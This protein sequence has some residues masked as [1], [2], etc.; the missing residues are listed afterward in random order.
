MEMMNGDGMDQYCRVAFLLWRNEKLAGYMM[1]VDLEGLEVGDMLVLDG[2]GM[3][4]GQ[5]VVEVVMVGS[6]SDCPEGPEMRRLL[7]P[8]GGGVAIEIW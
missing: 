2:I 6:G 8:R 1:V 7:R 5:W 4:G 3:G